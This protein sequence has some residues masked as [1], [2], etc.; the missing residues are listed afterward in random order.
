MIKNLITRIIDKLFG[1]IPYKRISLFIVDD[2]PFYAKLV[3]I[4]LEKS[5]YEDIKLFHT[6]ED[7]ISHLKKQSPDCIVLDH[8]LSENGLNGGDVLNYVKINNPNV[9]VVILSG[10]VDVEVAANMMKEGAY[11]YII[12]N[13]MAPFNLKN[14][15]T[16]LEDSINEKEKSKV[17]DKKIRSLYFIL[18]ILLWVIAIVVIF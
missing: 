4:N 6:G 8:K 9:N 2:I 16:R 18:L 1:T 14:T 12:K 17:R 10:Q 15:L 3:Q 5:G 7:V 13:D 11:D